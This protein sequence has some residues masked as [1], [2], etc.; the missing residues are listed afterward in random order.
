MVNGEVK[1][2]KKSARRDLSRLGLSILI[3]FLLNYVGSF[4]FHRFDLTSE[5]RY[6]LSPQSKSIAENIQ[7]TAFFRVYLDGPKLP[8]GMIR[9]RDETKEMLDEFRAY[10]GGKI[11][12]EFIDP[13]AN[14]NPEARL[15]LIKQLYK[16]GLN[17]IDMQVEESSGNSEQ[18]IIPGAILSYR[19]REMPMDILQRQG[20][21]NP[22][23]AINYSIEE[24]EYN[25]DNAVHKLTIDIK[26]SIAF[27]QG[28]GELDSIHTASTAK[29]LSEY[30]N[31]RSI[32]INHSEGS[33]LDSNFNPRYRAIIIAKP[34]TVF[35]EPDKLAIDQY[36]MYGGKVFW[37]V[38][39]LYTQ[40][41][42][43]A[44]T[45]KTIAFPNDM[46]LE[47][48]LF[49]YGVRL[50]NDLV[51]DFQCSAIPV[52]TALEGEQ[53]HFELSQWF[54]EP[55]V[56]PTGN[57]PIVK[58]LN[59]VEFNMAST[60]DT[61]KV[62]GVKKT[63]LLT[64]SK[65]TKVVTAPSRISIGITHL[66]LSEDLFRKSFMPL[67]VLLEGKFK[68]LYKGRLPLSVTNSSKYR[69]KDESKPTSQIV[70]SDGDVI[71]NETEMNGRVALPLGQDKWTH[72]IYSNKDFILNCMNYLCGDTNLLPVR[73]R[74]LQ[75]RLLDEKK[76][77]IQKTQW[78]VINLVVPVLLII[79]L[80]L[81]LAAVRK[82]KYAK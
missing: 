52:N 81:I 62:A 54:Y 13:S 22:T 60:L 17:P 31:V 35:S 8:S 6:T 67:A 27:I 37:L 51:L 5:K 63:I 80:G 53:P 21:T 82:A 78:Q 71:S 29:T 75:I 19:G 2:K 57:S 48:M 40:M 73:G 16:E 28:H 70:V 41:D 4:V 47:D 65:S 68:S 66:H 30:Y 33:L 15:S 72:E 20:N 50:D 45:G 38:D 77:K 64:T 44:K 32:L 23:A 46:N 58:N 79:F 49:Q 18:T 36:I 25:I 9:L 55:L 7:G 14:P 10:S 69:F 74:E 34:D 42:S 11:Q 61:I 39:P 1:H 59:L 24:L 43:L 3:L 56:G 12:Y 26:P 76:A